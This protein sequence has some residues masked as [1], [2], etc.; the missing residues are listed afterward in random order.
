MIDKPSLTSL[1]PYLAANP[2]ISYF[3]MGTHTNRSNMTTVAEWLACWTQAQKGSGSNR[4][5]DAVG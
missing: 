5:R 4:S 1:S 2:S 3:T